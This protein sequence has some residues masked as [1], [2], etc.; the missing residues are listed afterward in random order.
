MKYRIVLIDDSEL[1][2]AVMSSVL[3]DAGFEVQ[4]M[5]SLRK[6]VNAVLDWKPHLIVTDLNMPE[7]SGAQLCSWLRSQT[8]TARIPIV[9]CS[10]VPDAELAIVASEVGADGYL[11]KAHGPEAL[12]QRLRELCDEIVW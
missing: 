11:S 5:S 6:F 9:L 10:S 3:T 7:M 12:P 8:Q 4:A 1:V 2:L